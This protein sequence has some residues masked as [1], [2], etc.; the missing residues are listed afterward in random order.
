[1]AAHGNSGSVHDLQHVNRAEF[2]DA[3]FHELNTL[4][5]PSNSAETRQAVLLNA[6]NHP[7]L[8]RGDRSTDQRTV[9]TGSLNQRASP[10][11]ARP[12][13]SICPARQG[14]GDGS[15]Q[16]TQELRQE[17]TLTFRQGQ[18]VRFCMLLCV[19]RAV[20]M[21]QC[22]CT[23]LGFAGVQGHCA[24]C[25]CVRACARVCVSPDDLDAQQHHLQNVPSTI[26]S[27]VP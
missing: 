9:T 8:Q 26:S 2:Y 3:I 27:L 7:V 23:C 14:S 12:E 5:A 21:R 6:G 20:H 1:M 19:P 16:Q 22:A 24:P 4:Q 25:V 10:M 18:K 13:Q 15:Q 11:H 17:Q